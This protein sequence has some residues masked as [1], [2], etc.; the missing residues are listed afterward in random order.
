MTVPTSRDPTASSGDFD[1]CRWFAVSQ[2]SRFTTD[3]TNLPSE[4]FGH[5]G[6]EKKKVKEKDEGRT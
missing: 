4:T 1:Y 2:V 5:E 6:K 3:L